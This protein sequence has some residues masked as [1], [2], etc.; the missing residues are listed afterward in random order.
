MESKIKSRTK[1]SNVDIL[2]FM[3][4]V[5]QTHTKHYQ[6]DFQI[7][8]EMLL[9]TMEKKV[10]QDKRFIWLC[11]THG[12]WLLL[13]RNVFLK[14]TWE[15]NTFTFYAE[16]TSD[17]ILAYVIEITSG[18]QDSITGNIYVL[19]YA[20][21]YDHVQSVSLAAETVLMQYER[22][23]RIRKADERI[24]G[25]PDAEYGELVSIQY[26]P[27]SEEELKGLLRRER[28]E[29]VCYPE[30]CANAYISRLP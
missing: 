16:Q 10:Q 11:R 17:P 20:A 14:D 29:G 28:Q 1:F 9:R 6:S 24:S 27:H 18:A 4:D 25:H 30:G 15:F 19:D 7:D 22:G 3:G 26:Q 12:T 5:V 2:A 8:K 13:E 23:C 21:Y